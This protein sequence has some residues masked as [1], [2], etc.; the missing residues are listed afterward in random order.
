ME[1]SHVLS[2]L[3]RKCGLHLLSPA[4]NSFGTT[5]AQCQPSIGP[6]SSET[7][8]SC[9]TKSEDV[10]LSSSAI[11][12]GENTGL[13]VEER[14]ES[15]QV[16]I[17]GPCLKSDTSTCRSREVSS[18]TVNPIDQKPADSYVKKELPATSVLN[19]TSLSSG[20]M[21]AFNLHSKRDHLNLVL[22]DL[23]CR[24]K[25]LS[26]SSSF[27]ESGK[28]NEENASGIELD[29]DVSEFEMNP[30]GARTSDKLS[31]TA[32]ADF[33]KGEKSFGGRDE[34]SVQ[35]QSAENDDDRK[36]KPSF[37]ATSC[38]TN[39]GPS[40]NRDGIEFLLQARVEKEQKSLADEK[41]FDG[42]P[43]KRKKEKVL[44]CVLEDFM[45][46]TLQS[47]NKCPGVLKREGNCQL[48]A[49]L[50]M[51]PE[52]TESDVITS[53]RASNSCECS[54]ASEMDFDSTCEESFSR[55][56]ASFSDF[57]RDKGSSSGKKSKHDSAVDSG[58]ETVAKEL[59]SAATNDWD[60]SDDLPLMAN[61]EEVL[62]KHYIL[63]LSVKFSEKVMEGSIVLLVEPRNEEVTQRQFQMTLDSTLVNI[64]S[65]SEVVLPDDFKLKFYG[66]EQN[67]V[68][69]QNHEPSSGIFES[70]LGNILGDKSQKNLPFKRLPYSVYGWFVQIW[71]PDAL[72]KAWPRCI[73]IKY[74]TSPEGKSLTWA[75]DQD[76]KLVTQFRIKSHH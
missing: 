63:D 7:S 13:P 30:F 67:G 27:T 16:D 45:S 1:T 6:T 22:V 52:S 62:V 28:F 11:S 61:V 55:K 58:G 18:V 46:G 76:G 60:R 74:H 68:L 44:L 21:N 17:V 72:G 56:R 12:H 34:P 33:S 43:H 69:E 54:E 8:E 24:K 59:Q 31:S 29:K 66:Q 26:K 39:K 3:S 64:E 38:T 19:N 32:R 51:M 23:K 25:E 4:S 36:L 5:V 50:E 49:S 70:F 14:F 48:R 9:Q 65:V 73:W 10:G 53:E 47:T 57:S 41:D 42:P 40:Q 75:T 71:K 20:G 35:S 15:K 2:G 37:G